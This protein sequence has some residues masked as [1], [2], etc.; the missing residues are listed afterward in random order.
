MTIIQFAS[1]VMK[2]KPA[3]FVVFTL[4]LNILT[5]YTVNCLCKGKCMTLAY[6]WT[7]IPVITTLV[8]V[9]GLFDP[10]F[11]KQLEEETKERLVMY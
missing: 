5:A 9:Y 10:E 8:S 2:K 4:L 3:P 6:A 7:I 1:S 11:E